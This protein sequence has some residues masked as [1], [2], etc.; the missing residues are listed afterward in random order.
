MPEPDPELAQTGQGYGRRP[1]RGEQGLSVSTRTPAR[2]TLHH[3][4][5][6]SGAS[7]PLRQP[8]SPAGRCLHRPCPR[9]SE[10]QKWSKR[11]N[12]RKLPKAAG[13][14]RRVGA[15]PNGR[16]PRTENGEPQRGGKR[17]S[18]RCTGAVADSPCTG[19]ECCTPVHHG[20]AGRTAGGTPITAYLHSSRLA[21]AGRRRPP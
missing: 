2:G 16:K 8:C 9:A 14:K 10:P 12:S 18:C 13:L 20:T 6:P 15:R 5:A 1:A 4:A 7:R 19:V 17:A 3:C 21:L 11:G